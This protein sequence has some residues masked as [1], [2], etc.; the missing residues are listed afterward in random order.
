VLGAVTLTGL[1][2]LYLP[3]VEFETAHRE[4][5]RVGTLLSHSNGYWYVIECKDA[6]TTIPSF[7]DLTQSREG[8]Q[9]IIPES[10]DDHIGKPNKYTQALL[11]AREQY[12]RRSPHTV[13]LAVSAIPDDNAGV[14]RFLEPYPLTATFAQFATTQDVTLCLY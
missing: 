9:L 5:Q 8:K 2:A 4:N 3:S 14:V 10:S 11:D 7:P 13:G 6:E 1:Q 12:Q